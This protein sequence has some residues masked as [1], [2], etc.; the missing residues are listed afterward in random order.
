MTAFLE[1][2]IIAVSLA[3]DALTV[4]IAGGV[5]ARKVKIADA[6]KVALFF[7]IFQALMP[8]IGWLIGAFAIGYVSAFSHWIA[9]F[10]LGLIGI[11]MIRVSL[12]EGEDEKKNIL[13][14]KTLTLLAIATSIDAL[15]VGITLHLLEIP[16]TVA[17][18]I[19]GLVTLVLCFFGYLFGNVLGKF[20]GRRFEIVG[21]I[22]LIA[23]GTKIFVEHL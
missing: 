23:I 8:I 9:F 11:S 6:L 12:K 22:A 20:F 19:I 13:E 18:L 4:S 21:G 14:L 5:S 15:I 7:G 3:M 2:F 16:F 1:V 10:L 17:I